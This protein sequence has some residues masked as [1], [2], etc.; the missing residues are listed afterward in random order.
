MKKGARGSL[1][2]GETVV[3]ATAWGPATLGAYDPREWW[4]T[5]GIRLYRGSEE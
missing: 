5:R 3:V 1:K 2:Y 4:G